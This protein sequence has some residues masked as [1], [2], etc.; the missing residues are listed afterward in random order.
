MSRGSVW[1]AGL[2]AACLAFATAGCRGRGHK[3]YDRVPDADVVANGD[4][5]VDASIGDAVTLNPLLAQDSASD[6]IIGLVFDALLRYNPG[7][8]LE[9]D[10][11]KSWQVRDKGLRIVF[12][13]RRGVLWQDGKSFTS[14]DVAFTYR[15]IMDPK[16]ACPFKA[17]FSLVSRVETPDPWTVV[18]TYRKPFAP[19]L[20]AWAE[21]SILPLHLL[22]G[23]KLSGGSFD[24]HPVGT[25]PYCLVSWKR[26]QSIELKANPLYWEGEPHI[27]RYL[28]QIIPD[29][30]TQVLE[31]KSQNVD[32]VN[33]SSV[34]DQYRDLSRSASFREIGRTFRFPGFNEYEF[35]G[36]NLL[37]PMFQDKRVR[38]ALSYA[39]DRKALIDSILLGYGQPCS[40]P[41]VPSMPAYNPRVTPVP[42]D[43]GKAEKLL[44]EAGW[45][46]GKDGWREKDGRPMAF[47]IAT[48]Q[49]NKVREEVATILQQQFARLGIRARVQILAW[50]L[51]DSQYVSKKNF[52]T[53]VL[54]WGLGM[55]PDQY[56]I[57]DSKESGP[58]GLNFISYKNPRVDR[59]LE[60]GRTTFDWKKRVRI[61]R[62]F[63][64]LIAADQ[65]V[66]FLFAPDSLSAVNRRFHGLLVTKTGCMWYWPTRW[67]VPK[68]IQLYP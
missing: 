36:F 22:K 57:W 56:V 10:L 59:L 49:G 48:N 8:E 42:Y 43:L 63:H 24:S 60:E 45:K 13:L 3:D 14:A 31:M 64:A 34:P 25:G 52:D 23:R 58:G 46:R 50:S 65:P 27:R 17:D 15:A 38:W 5:R 66:C 32:T 35:F 2:V 41:Y 40:G 4:A 30:A 18:V 53:V 61:Y 62:K 12:H 47:T 54:G 21:A 26:N 11:A 37:K 44:D 39:I 29:P 55:D 33:L 7:L 9:G 16:V 1:A 28:Y 51:F 19:A 6:D 20:S 67:Y 68:S